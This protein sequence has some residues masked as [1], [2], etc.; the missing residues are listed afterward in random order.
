MG[1]CKECRISQQAVCYACINA[2]VDDRVRS[3]IQDPDLGVVADARVKARRDTIE[4][5]ARWLENRGHT[6]RQ[7]RDAARDLRAALL[8]KQAGE[9][10]EGPM[11]GCG[12][13]GPERPDTA[14]AEG[15]GEVCDACLCAGG[16][17]Q[18]RCGKCRGVGRAP[19][20]SR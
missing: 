2:I 7:C 4:E 13:L 9:A 3:I 1:I 18:A 20:R 12:L 14:P 16:A 8:G 19:G 10:P 17:L 5:A 11:S 6:Q 15:A